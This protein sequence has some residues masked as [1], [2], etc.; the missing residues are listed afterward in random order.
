MCPYY[1]S[2][3]QS[4]E[5]NTAL[6]LTGGSPH[7]FFVYHWTLDRMVLLPSC[8]LSDTITS[9]QAKDGIFLRYSV[10]GSTN[11]NYFD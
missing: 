3:C 11:G 6:T 5:R 10:V 8:Q 1:H 7:P 4:T 2:V 9:N